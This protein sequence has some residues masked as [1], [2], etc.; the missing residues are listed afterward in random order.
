LRPDRVTV[1]F[2]GHVAGCGLPVIRLHDTRHGACSLMLAG[3][4]PIEIVQMILGHSSPEITRRVYAHLMRKTAAEQV[5]RA[6]KLLTRHRP[7]RTPCEQS[8]SN[9]PVGRL[10]AGA[11]QQ[12]AHRAFPQVGGAQSPARGLVARGGVEPPTFRFSVGRSY[13]LSYLAVVVVRS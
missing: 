6:S 10:P 2:E 7:D 12:H 5:E 8:V 9:T 4:V 11:G 1:A 13:Q 3:G